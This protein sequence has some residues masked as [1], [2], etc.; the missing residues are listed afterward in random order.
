MDVV[1]SIILGY[2]ES[3]EIMRQ[4]Q[5]GIDPYGKPIFTWE[6]AATEYIF[7]Q[8]LTSKEVFGSG[9]QYS[10]DDAKGFFMKTSV[11][12]ENDQIVWGGVTYAV[13]GL[14]PLR[15]NSIT[16]FLRSYLKRVIGA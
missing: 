15:A 12:Q 11:T 2:G 16:M 10:I 9:G 1:S 13:R 7:I 4:I 6:T 5:T 3:L 8:P 14:Q